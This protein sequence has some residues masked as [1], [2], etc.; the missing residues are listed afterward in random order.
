M[1]N[2]GGNTYV[3][4]LHNF[5]TMLSQ[6]SSSRAAR[7]NGRGDGQQHDRKV[8]DDFTYWQRFV[9]EFFSAKGVLKL[10]MV[11]TKSAPDEYGKHF[12][13]AT[14][15]LARYYYLHFSSG[16]QSI[17]MFVDGVKEKNLNN[18]IH[19]LEA[20]STFIYWSRNGHQVGHIYGYVFLDV[21]T[22]C[23]LWRQDLYEPNSTSIVRWIF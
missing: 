6:A 2:M 1:Q 9:E 17:Q 14:P 20:N 18:G 16:I 3:L 19:V 23:S 12:E 8:A 5:G 10:A 22:P 11:P 7:V 4:K 21:L 15:A 13:I